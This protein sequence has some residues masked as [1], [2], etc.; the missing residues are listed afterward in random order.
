MS[1]D[2]K[3]KKAYQ[4]WKKKSK[5]AIPQVGQMEDEAQVGQAKQNWQKRRQGRHGFKE[6]K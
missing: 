1:K 3:G 6:T 5:L 4:Q 2:Q